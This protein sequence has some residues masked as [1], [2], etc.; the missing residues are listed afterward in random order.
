MVVIN[1]YSLHVTYLF[2][3]NFK[4]RLT[5]RLRYVPCVAF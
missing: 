2:T 4:F 5:H 3:Q 1:V